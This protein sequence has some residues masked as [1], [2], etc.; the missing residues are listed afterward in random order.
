MTWKLP[1]DHDAERK[2]RINAHAD[3]IAQLINVPPERVMTDG[4]FGV[5]LTPNQVDLLFTALRSQGYQNA[6]D[7]LKVNGETAN[8]EGPERNLT[9]WAVMVSAASFLEGGRDGTPHP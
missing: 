4:S 8:V 6:I 5:V 3:Q 1:P 9:T 7:A 2:D